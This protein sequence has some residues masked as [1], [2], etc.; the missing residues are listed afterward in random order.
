MKAMAATKKVV[1]TKIATTLIAVQPLPLGMNLDKQDVEATSQVFVD[2]IKSSRQF[3]SVTNSWDMSVPLNANGWPTT[4]FGVVVFNTIPH[5]YGTYSLSFTGSAHISGNGSSAPVTISNVSYNSGTN[6][7][8]AQ[9]TLPSNSSG[10]DS[11]DLEFTHTSGPGLTNVQLIRPG[12]A[13]N[14]TQ[15]FST[16]FINALAPFGTLRYK[17]FLQTDNNPLVN[18]SDRP[19][20]SDA[21]QTSSRGVALGYVIA[22]A[23][24]TGKDIWLNIPEGATD[25]YIT[26]MAEFFKT[27]LTNPNIHIYLEYSNEV[28]NSLFQAHT[29]NLNAALAEGNAGPCQLNDYGATPDSPPGTAY[30]YW[31]WRRV[32]YQSMHIGQI[33][34]SV[35][36]QGN[37]QVRPVLSG[38]IYATLGM[39]DSLQWIQKY[40]GT[41]SQLFYGIAGSQYASLNYAGS[42]NLGN[43]T[44]SQTLSVESA[45]MTQKIQQFSANMI[46]NG[47]MSTSPNYAALANYYGLQ[48]T[49]YEGGPDTAWGAPLANMISANNDPQMGTLVT[50]FLESWFQDNP[51]GLFMYTE[52]CCPNNQYG[53]YGMYTDITQASVKSTAVDAVAGMTTGNL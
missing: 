25:D 8:T 7:T 35:F 4:D 16:A 19:H 47:V 39:Q 26:Q 23:N 46:Y 20:E 17:D 15:V 13:A 44:V 10:L 45:A 53:Q 12:Y 28:W 9:V 41:P 22:L 29:A 38:D 34:N 51:T 40:Y 11:L 3:G 42:S 18:W 1:T 48:N 43:L 6:T 21:Q 36:G 27:N 52:L 24:Q 2:A 30:H 32:A 50:S 33:F 31:A 49:A 5:G 37:S 14:T